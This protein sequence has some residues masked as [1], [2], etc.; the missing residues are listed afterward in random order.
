MPTREQRDRRDDALT[1][2]SKAW[3]WEAV[4][5]HYFQRLG[6]SA[7]AAECRTLANQWAAERD[8]LFKEAQR[9]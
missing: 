2:A 1:K 7:R 8:R 5:L 3:E 9:G 6:N 4:R